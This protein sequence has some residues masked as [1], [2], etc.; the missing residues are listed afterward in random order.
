MF[1]F[2]LLERKG[3]GGALALGIIVNSKNNVTFD[4]N[5]I[6]GPISLVFSLGVFVL[7]ISFHVANITT[8]NPK[9]R[10]IPYEL[11]IFFQLMAN[12][13]MLRISL[14]MYKILNWGF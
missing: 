4:G 9:L 7:A 6:S 8:P 1:D 11:K 2:A 14:I 10:Y 12:L 13:I 5:K 3:P